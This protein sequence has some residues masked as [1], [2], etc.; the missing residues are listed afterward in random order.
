M[1]RV[2]LSNLDFEHQ[3]AE[4]SRTD[5]GEA[6]RQINAE[7]ASVW[8]AIAEPGD[9]VWS[10]TGK[11]IFEDY[12]AWSNAPV[13]PAQIRWITDE[14]QL[15]RCDELCPWGWS[16]QVAT[17]GRWRGLTCSAPPIEA[18]R[19]VNSRRFA[20]ELEQNWGVNPTGTKLISSPDELV[21]ALQNVASSQRWILKGLFGMSGRERFVGH[22]YS[23]KLREDL[24]PLLQRLI[25]RRQHPLQTTQGE[26]FIPRVPK[27]CSESKVDEV[28]P[29]AMLAWLVNHLNRD[30]VVIFEPWLDRIA[31]ASLQWDIPQHG[32]PVFVG[33]VPMIEP[34][35]SSGGYF[36]SRIDPRGPPLTPNPSPQRGEGSDVRECLVSA[37]TMWSDA[38]DVTS[39]V[40]REVQRRGYFGPLG[41]DAM[42][43]RDDAG[44]TRLRP[45]QDV[46]ARYTMG[47]LA[48]GWRRFLK[49]N[50]FGSWLHLN[51][52][53]REP[54]ASRR[55]IEVARDSLPEG[56]RLLWTSP[57]EIEGRVPGKQTVLLAAPTPAVR[58]TTEQA[59]IQS[60]S[61]ND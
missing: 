35:N 42:L 44:Q 23:V 61:R 46:N 6:V 26:W 31:E 7:L 22:G 24:K 1:P 4:P 28:I 39:H 38:I 49:P 10:P 27:F 53:V 50:E 57:V 12:P 33:A 37:D 11:P 17:W 21:A 40:A 32:E 9:A 19:E 25:T 48:L 20:F 47:R 14:S 13:S 30:G 18:V 58:A 54:A 16:E 29:R 43:Y 52:N 59:L 56:V 15:A 5:F 41:I 60:I 51:W 8:L 45:I 36:G 55:R 34:P 2:L 3:L